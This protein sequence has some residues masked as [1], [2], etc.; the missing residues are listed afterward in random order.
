[1]IGEQEALVLL[2]RAGR[3]AQGMDPPPHS[4]TWVRWAL[5]G[6]GTP[7]VKLETLRLGGRRFTTREAISRFVAQLT[8]HEAV[9]ENAGVE[10]QKH[11]AKA[12]EELDHDKI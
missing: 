4:S 12:E 6:V 9:D 7:R 10:R 8:G 5:R 3:F 11:L 2:T 1:M